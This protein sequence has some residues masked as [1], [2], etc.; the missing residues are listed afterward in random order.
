MPSGDGVGEDRLVGSLR[1][2]KGRL[3]GMAEYVAARTRFYD[4]TLLAACA[5]GTRQVV[6]VGAG[7]DGR[8]L[9]FRQPGVQFFEVDH[10]ATQA[11]KQARLRRLG[12]DADDV[13]FVPVDL[14]RASVAGALAAAGQDAGSPS[15]FMC[16][17]LTMY[18]PMDV[19]V[20]L[21]RSLA[22][23]TAPGS[24]LAVDFMQPGRGHPFVSRVQLRFVRVAVATLGERMVTPVSD[25]GAASLL[26]ETGWAQVELRPPPRSLPVVFAL[27]SR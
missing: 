7:Y 12:I 2:P 10:P 21:L 14:G 6:I 22:D 15:H 9:R 16:E 17:G 11:D 1:V 4:D 25:A 5:A 27:A 23:R 24:T 26:R 20:R 18:L 3:P 8:S 19:L 13:R